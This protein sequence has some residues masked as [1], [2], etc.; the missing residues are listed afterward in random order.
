MGFMVIC[1]SSGKIV[2]FSKA[3]PFKELKML[4][5]FSVTHNFMLLMENDLSAL[6]NLQKLESYKTNWRMFTLNNAFF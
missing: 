1:Y 4:S 2:F 3:K 6:L 5:L